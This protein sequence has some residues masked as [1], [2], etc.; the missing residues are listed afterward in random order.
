MMKINFDRIWNRGEVNAKE[1]IAK[2][3]FFVVYDLND[4]A[5]FENREAAES[6]A[7][8]WLRIQAENIETPLCHDWRGLVAAYVAVPPHRVAYLEDGDV[9]VACCEIDDDFEIDAKN[10]DAV[11]IVEKDR[12]GF[13]DFV[14]T[15]GDTFSGAIAY[16]IALDNLRTQGR[17]RRAD[18]RAAKKAAKAAR[19]AA[20]LKRL[21]MM[22][23]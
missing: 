11:E 13:G 5:V 12:F 17:A 15:D 21:G 16:A 3:S 6:C 4:T 8:E 14:L 7:C 23:V 1:L 19:K 2:R 10:E 20:A 22:E 9:V 18:R